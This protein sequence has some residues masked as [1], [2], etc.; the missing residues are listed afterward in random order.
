MMDLTPQKTHS[1]DD[2]THTP[3]VSILMPCYNV[4]ETIDEAVASLLGQTLREH[5][6]VAVD[7]GSSDSTGDRLMEWVERDPRLRVLSLPH[8]GII[9][10]LNA[11][12]AACRAPLVSRMDA[13]DRAHPERLARQVTCLEAHPELALVSCLV[14]GFPVD[15]VREGF[16][17]YIDWLNSLVSPEAI[18]REIFIESPLAH[19]SVTIRKAWIERIGGY[20]DHGWP[21]DYDLWLRM[22]LAGAR[23]AKVPEVLLYWREHPTRLTR[24]DTRYSTDNF[25]RAKAHYLCRG[26]LLDRDAIIIWGAGQMGR[27]MSKYLLRNDVSLT[28]FVDIDPAK[29]GRTRRGKPI[30]SPEELMDW[31][32]RYDRPVVLVAVG[33]RGVRELIRQR[34]N[35][36]GLLEGDDWWA[37]A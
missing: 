21:E 34:L 19:P 25:L 8:E 13:D 16:R 29:I 1:L 32:S 37:V 27:R 17:L 18:E 36:M 3:T 14:E 28:A 5:E 6:V 4:E 35:E 23:F 22:C 10:A 33:S 26:V 7:D 20:Q 30:I 11:G 2:S 24:T 31:W 9:P 15:R 12:L